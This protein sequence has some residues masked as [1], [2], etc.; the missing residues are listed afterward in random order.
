MRYQPIS[1]SL[2][3]KNREKFMSRM[4]PKGLAVFNA[5][6]IYPIGADSTMPFQQDRNLYYLSGV[7]QEESMLV[8]FPDAADKKHREILFVRETNEHIAVWILRPSSTD[9]WL[10]RIPFTST[11]M[12]TTVLPMKR[13]PAKTV[14]INGSKTII[15]HIRSP[16]PILFY[17]IFVV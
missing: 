7:D 17:S 13:K 11:P 6:D 10:R 1:S 12:N 8:L 4:R 16:N 15:R 9:S 3:T 2:F 14:S 5:N